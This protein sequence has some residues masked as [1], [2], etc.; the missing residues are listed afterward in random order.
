MPSEGVVTRTWLRLKESRGL[1]L[2]SGGGGGSLRLERFASEGAK[3]SAG[4]EMAL[5]VESVLNGGVKR[6]EALG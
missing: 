1:S 2:S 3:R 4:N 5:D 6:Q